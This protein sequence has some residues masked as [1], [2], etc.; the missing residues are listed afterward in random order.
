VRLRIFQWS[1]RP[2]TNGRERCLRQEGFFVANIAYPVGEEMGPSLRRQVS[3]VITRDYDR[4]SRVWDRSFV[5]ATDE[6]RRFLLDTAGLRP[7]ERVL[8]VGTGTGAAALL[9]ARCVGQTGRVLGIDR[10]SAMLAKARAKASRS[11]LTNV[12]FR[13]MDGSALRL[14]RASF[15]VVISSFGTPEG[16]YDGKAVFR[17]WLRVLRPG[18]RLCFAEN[19]GIISFYK[20]LARVLEKHKVKDPGPALATRRR[21]WQEARE[22]RCRM[23]EINGDEPRKVGRLMRM[24]GFRDVRVTLRRSSVL[25]PSAQTIL[26]LFLLWGIAE[27]YAEMRP[28][29]RAAFRRELLRALRRYETPEG[30]RLPTRT[31]FFFG[32]KG[33]RPARGRGI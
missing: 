22:E 7:G 33:T 14:S 10:S 1:V 3:H 13:R 31:N 28:K 15:D 9:A 12:T 29:A 21:L 23:P 16:L 30:L 8:D 27:E 2:T 25:L 17:D 18:G 26:R 20:I 6:L 24:A 5:P 4:V 32:R 11:G 19:P